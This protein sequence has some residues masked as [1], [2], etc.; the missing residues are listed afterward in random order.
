M[1][2]ISD[3][4]PEI[5]YHN[6][7]KRIKLRYDAEND[8]ALITLPPFTRKSSALK[9]ASNHIDWLIE[10]RSKSP[11]LVLIKPGSIIPF[12]GIDKKIIHDPEGSARV[13]MTEDEMIVG[14]TIEGL[15]VRIENFLKK[16]ARLLIEPIAHEYAEKSGKSFKRIHIRDTKSRWGSCSSNGTL[17]FSWR[18]IMAPPEILEYVVAHEV[19]HLSEMNHSAAFWDVVDTLVPNSKVSRKWLKKDGQHLML[20][21]SH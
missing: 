20:I 8:R 7:A 12:L 4:N 16:E 9:F 2:S 1:V 19:A 11:E 15:G 6:R 18:L 3:F 13:L 21:K 17:S 10:Q 14:G 5:K